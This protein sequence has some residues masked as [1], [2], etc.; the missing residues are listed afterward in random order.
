MDLHKLK[1]FVDLSKTLNY[2]DTAENLFTTQGNISKQVIALEKELGVSLF[3]RAHRK[4]ELTPQGEITLPYAVK[5]ISEYT[6]LQN[7]LNEFQAAKNLTIEMHT[8]PTMPSYESFSLITKFL[9]KHPEVHMQLQEEES[10]NLVTSL[11]AGK[12]ELIFARTFDFDDPDLERIVME[13]DDFVAVLPKQHPLANEKNLNLAQLKNDRFMILGPSTNLYQPVIKLCQKAGFKPKI[14]YEGTRV[15]LI[16]QMVQNNLGVS[17]M[18]KKTA[19]NFDSSDFVMV[20]L[21]ENIKNNLSFIR[22]R[23]QHSSANEMFWR[24]VQKNL[25]WGIQKS[26]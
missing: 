25:D 6:D 20:P 26:N 24:Y 5:I 23:G 14:T 11:K 2:T 17:L 22:V 9:Q 13:A 10:Y 16:M 19:E 4:I 18:M 7:S 15:D 3:K 8:I 12:C 21:T 1:I